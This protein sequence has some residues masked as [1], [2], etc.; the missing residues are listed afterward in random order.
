MVVVLVAPATSAGAAEPDAASLV[1]QVRDREAWIDRVESLSI[2][3]VQHWERTPKGLELSRRRLEKDFPGTRPEN[4]PNLRKDLRYTIELAFD[5][6]RIRL[7]VH[8]EG[9][10]DDLRVWDGDRFILQNR[11]ADW[12]GLRPDQDGTLYKRDLSMLSWLVW[13]NFSCFRAAPHVFWWNGP[14]ERADIGRMTARPEDFAYERQAEFHGL[15]CHVVSH[16]ASWTTLFIGVEDGRLHGIRSGAQTT[17]KLTDSMVTL[18]RELGRQVRDEAEMGRQAPSLSAEERER[19]R[20]LGAARM[21]ELID[22]VFEYRLSLHKEVAPGCRLP[23]VQSIRFFEVDPEGKAFES[24]SNELRV[25]R[26]KVNEPLPDALFTV[27]LKE[28][29]WVNDQ[30]EDPPL[31]YRHKANMTPEEWSAIREAAKKY[32]GRQRPIKK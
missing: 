8:D 9:Y 12:P 18:F 5:R 13:T 28:G 16:W 25:L 22:P 3:A 31:R 20:R 30:T 21:T 27:S 14:Q 26:V 17:R 2:K 10:S 4:D 15:R 11:Y 7:R 32:P 1:R 29:E 6:K 19:M 24:H 23:L